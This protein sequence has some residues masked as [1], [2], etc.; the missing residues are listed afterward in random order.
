M[1]LVGRILAYDVTYPPG[2]MNMDPSFTIGLIAIQFEKGHIQIIDHETFAY[3]NLKRQAA[4]D[5]E[6]RRQ[7]PAGSIVLVVFSLRYSSSNWVGKQI[8]TTNRA[9][10]PTIIVDAFHVSEAM[11][12]GGSTANFTPPME[13]P[14]RFGCNISDT[15]TKIR[16]FK[17]KI[18][19]KKK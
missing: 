2:E 19:K 9:F 7:L 13:K 8:W 4:I 14:I 3:E 1:Y 6:C 12:A 5:W 16:Q 15:L 11:A 18:A 17:E 10:F